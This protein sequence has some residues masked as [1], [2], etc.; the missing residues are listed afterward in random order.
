M[1]VKKPVTTSPRHSSTTNPAATTLQTN[2]RTVTIHLESLT[3][4]NPRIKAISSTR[5]SRTPCGEHPSKQ[6]LKGLLSQCN[7]RIQIQ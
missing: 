3:R 6:L 7:Q 5:V 2:K 4:S 1:E